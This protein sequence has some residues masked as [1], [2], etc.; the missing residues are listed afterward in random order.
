MTIM[1][2]VKILPSYFSLIVVI[3]QRGIP[4][5]CIGLA[6][7]LLLVSPDPVSLLHSDVFFIILGTFVVCPLRSV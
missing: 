3:S 5:L 1:I 4:S 2:S 6:I 7:C